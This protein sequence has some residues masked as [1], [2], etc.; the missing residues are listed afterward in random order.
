MSIAMVFPGQGSQSQGMQADLAAE[1]PFVQETYA[2]ASEILGYD[3]W[4]LVQEGP[5][6]KLAETVVTQPAML[7]AGYV[8]WLAW[9]EAGG[10]Q[11]GQMAGHRLCQRLDIAR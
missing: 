2:V 11:P 8:S 10:A 6:E 5:V 9:R 4:H 7:T 1:F 3:L